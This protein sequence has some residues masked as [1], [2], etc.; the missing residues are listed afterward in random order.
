MTAAEHQRLVERAAFA[1]R[2]TKRK[3][4][5]ELRQA[6]HEALRRDVEAGQRARR[7]FIDRVMGEWA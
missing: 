1:P 3:R 4:E 6:T 5:A 7:A 2:G